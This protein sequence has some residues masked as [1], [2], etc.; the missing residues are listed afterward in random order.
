VEI[1][2]LKADSFASAVDGL[3]PASLALLDMSLRQGIEEETIADLLGSDPADVRA[4]REE[5]LERLAAAAGLRGEGAT[6]EVSALL[7]AMPDERW[8]GYRAARRNGERR[9]EKLLEEAAALASA[10]AAEPRVP[11]GRRTVVVPALI[12]MGAAAVAVA[13]VLARS[14]DDTDSGSRPQGGGSQAQS[15]ERSP[16]GEPGAERSRGP[17]ARLRPVGA[18]PAPA[19]ARVRL[20][21]NRLELA[22]R[23]LPDPGGGAY[24]VWLYDSVAE[25]VPVARSETDRIDADVELPASARDHRYVDVSLEPA[26]GNPNHSGASVLR[27]PLAKLLP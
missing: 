11:T 8:P 26:D 21:G 19:R 10:G 18:R 25:A 5:A 6:G 7:A 9:D 22:V 17:A 27:A 13:L 3:D 14:G 20:D 1:L 2:R 23:G 4:I 12:A 16:A 24:Q 15:A